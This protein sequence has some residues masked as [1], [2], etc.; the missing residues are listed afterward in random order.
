MDNNLI[1]LFEFEEEDSGAV[2]AGQLDE[3]GNERC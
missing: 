2:V 3:K 1:A